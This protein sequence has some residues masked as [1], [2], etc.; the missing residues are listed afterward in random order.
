MKHYRQEEAEDLFSEYGKKNRSKVRGRMMKK[1]YDEK[2][3]IIGPEKN[4]EGQEMAKAIYYIENKRFPVDKNELREY[5]K[6]LTKGHK[7]PIDFQYKQKLENV[8]GLQFVEMSP[9]Q[10]TKLMERGEFDYIDKDW[11][12]EKEISYLGEEEIRIR[13]KEIAEDPN[14]TLH[15]RAEGLVYRVLGVGFD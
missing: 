10:I 1:V 7:I 12:D 13:L 4:K 14:L 3:D 2:G 8:Y 6:K 5:Y 9:F 11:K 15:V